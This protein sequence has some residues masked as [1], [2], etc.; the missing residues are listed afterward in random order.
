MIVDGIHN[1]R[2]KEGINSLIEG[3]SYKIQAIAQERGKASHQAL[4][5]HLALGIISRYLYAAMIDAQYIEL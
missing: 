1:L 5:Y 2:E 3:V 4:N